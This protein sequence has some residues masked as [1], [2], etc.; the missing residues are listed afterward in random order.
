MMKENYSHNNVLANAIVECSNNVFLSHLA[1]REV[2]RP[3]LE[4]KDE[5]NV[6]IRPLSLVFAAMVPSS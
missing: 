4:P 1:P 2:R 6:K 5:R 3:Q